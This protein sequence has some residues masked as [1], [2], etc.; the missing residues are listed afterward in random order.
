MVNIEGLAGYAQYSGAQTG[1]WSAMWQFVSVPT[2]AKIAAA[3]NQREGDKAGIAGFSVFPNPA[4]DIVNVESAE[5]KIKTVVIYDLTGKVLKVVDFGAPE[6]Q[7]QL[8]VAEFKTG[9]FLMKVYT[10]NGQTLNMKFFKE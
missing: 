4:V 1:W 2:G 5:F 3:A 9:M 7:V 8:K 10:K 6:N